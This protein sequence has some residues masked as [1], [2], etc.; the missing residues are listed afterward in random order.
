MDDDVRW[1]DDDEQRS[2]RGFISG[3][4]TLIRAF[5]RDLLA[6]HGLTLDDYALLVLLSESPGRRLR[7]MQLADAAIVPRPQVTYRV[8]RLEERGAVERLPC[9]DDARGTLAHLTDDGFALL[10]DAA[11]TH[12][13]NVREDFLDLLDPEEFET[14]GLALGRVHAHLSGTGEPALR[15]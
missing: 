8:K 10:H 14:I 15:A 13:T 6:G 3:V 4:Q 2:W 7:M 1:L 11:R 9:P 5:E 12:V